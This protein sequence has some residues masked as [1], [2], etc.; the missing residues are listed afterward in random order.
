MPTYAYR[1]K[2]CDCAFDIHQAFSDDALT[3]CPECGEDRL[4]KV[5]GTVGV[6]FKGSGFYA[7]DSRSSS[8]ASSPAASSSSASSS[9]SSSGDSSS[10]SASS[11]SSS[12]TA[13]AAS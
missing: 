11:S 12:S 7:T 6:T 13:A 5:F 3:T 10:S 1:C 9:S 4:R 8:T 2:N